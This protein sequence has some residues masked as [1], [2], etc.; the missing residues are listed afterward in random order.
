ML[1]VKTSAAAIP[2]V[3]VVAAGLGVRF[4]EAGS[5]AARPVVARITLPEK[6]P[7][8]DKTDARE[9]TA[10]PPWRR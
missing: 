1:S 2:P 6:R 9:V 8:E 7:E 10:R 4:G 3:S 5:G